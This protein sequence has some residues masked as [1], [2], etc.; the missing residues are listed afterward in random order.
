MSQQGQKYISYKPKVNI[1][2]F[3]RHRFSSEGL[4]AGNLVLFHKQLTNNQRYF[5]RQFTFNQQYYIQSTTYKSS[6]L[7]ESCFS[8]FYGFVFQICCECIS[9]AYIT[10]EIF[11]IETGWCFVTFCQLSLKSVNNIFCVCI[12][13][14]LRILMYQYV[15]LLIT[16]IIIYLFIFC[17]GSRT[18]Y[19]HT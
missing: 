13:S 10:N 14:S 12:K 16:Q 5:L 15:N 9:N 18:Q 7:P 19:L 6:E 2:S 8:S 3:K 11:K 17:T 4:A 1:Q